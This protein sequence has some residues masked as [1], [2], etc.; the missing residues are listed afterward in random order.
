MVG[1]AT[2]A[3]GS[4]SKAISPRFMFRKQMGRVAVT[5]PSG[6]AKLL[7]QSAVTPTPLHAQY[8]AC[9]VGG[10]GRLAPPP[11]A[12]E[13]PAP[14]T[15]PFEPVTSRLSGPKPALANAGTRGIATHPASPAFVIVGVQRLVRHHGCHRPTRRP[16]STRPSPS[17]TG[18]RAGAAERSCVSQP[19]STPVRHAP[20]PSWCLN[21]VG[22][23]GGG[24]RAGGESRRG[25]S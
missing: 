15:A 17:R 3:R 22:R 11:P 16:A 21:D 24:A 12:R 20:A 5:A 19:P 2:L 1:C 10:S 23:H 7:A 14:A 8:R 25:V 6:C 9:P 13:P 4:C 18:T